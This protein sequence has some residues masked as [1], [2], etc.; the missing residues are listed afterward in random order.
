MILGFDGSTEASE[1]TKMRLAPPSITWDPHNS[2]S[3]VVGFD[4]TLQVVDTREMEVT[5]QCSTAHKGF[6]RS[7]NF[8]N[9]VCLSF[10]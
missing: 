5:H 1:S 2:R 9:T 3:C 6:V 4:S 8:S 7:V 10:Y